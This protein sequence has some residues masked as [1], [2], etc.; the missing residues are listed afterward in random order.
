[1]SDPFFPVSSENGLSVPW[2]MILDGVKDAQTPTIPAY[3]Q[4]PISPIPAPKPQFPDYSMPPVQ[5]FPIRQPMPPVYQESYP[6]DYNIPINGVCEAKEVIVQ[7][8]ITAV[9]QNRYAPSIYTQPTGG[10]SPLS[11]FIG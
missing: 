6:T 2:E 9:Q 8:P 5:Q 11:F 10:T 1:M 3:P 4:L 7:C